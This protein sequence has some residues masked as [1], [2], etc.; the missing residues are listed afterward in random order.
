MSL[1]QF[2]SIDIHRHA[3]SLAWFRRASFDQLRAMNENIAALQRPK[4]AK[5]SNSSAVVTWDVQ[6]TAVANLSTP[7]RVVRRLFE[8]NRDLFPVVSR[9]EWFNARFGF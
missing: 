1:N 6:P 8:N 5:I 3:H 4:Q 7:L 2:P 9:E